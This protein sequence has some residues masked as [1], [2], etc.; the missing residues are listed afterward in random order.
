MRRHF[1]NEAKE[2][3]HDTTRGANEPWRFTPLFEANPFAFSNYPNQSTGY[4]IPTPGGLN[5]L[6]H[7]QAGD[8]HT[9]G[10][11]I[12]LGTPLSMPMSDNS[13]HVGPSLDMHSFH[14][15][16]FQANTFMQQS[17]YAPQASYA[18]SSFVHQDSGYGAMDGS[19]KNDPSA[20]IDTHADPTFALQKTPSNMPAPPLP[21][22]EKYVP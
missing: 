1:E 18:P 4:Y 6:Y 10:M 15:Q 16:I 3:V 8:L 12:H 7:S 11:A 2:Q 19:P 20:Q 13:M 9:P 17:H 21:S 14:Q 22:S 5:P